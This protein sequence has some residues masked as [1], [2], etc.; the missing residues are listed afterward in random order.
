MPLCVFKAVD[1]NAF[2]FCPPFFSFFILV[3]LLRTELDE[4]DSL[5]EKVF[6]EEKAFLDAA[7]EATA[8]ETATLV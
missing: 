3:L 7:V 1:T 8:M 5:Q 4:N 2:V 6:K